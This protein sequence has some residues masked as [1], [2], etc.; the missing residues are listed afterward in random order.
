[1]VNAQEWL[2]QNYPRVLRET[3]ST[4]IIGRN[5]E[6]LEGE[7]KL[8]GFTNLK[9]F[10]CDGSN[11]LTNLDLSQCYNLE[12]VWCVGSNLTSVEFLNHFPHPEKVD[13]IFLINNN[14]SATDIDFFSRFVNL[15]CLCIGTTDINKIEQG[16][17]NRFYG[18]LYSLRNLNKLKE[19]SICSTD[20]DDGAE[21]LPDSL[22]T[23]FCDNYRVGARVEAINF[24]LNEYDGDFGRDVPELKRAHQRIARKLEDNQTAFVHALQCQA[25]QHRQKVRE[26]EEQ[27]TRLQVQ[28]DSQK[29]QEKDVQTQEKATQTNESL[30]C[31]SIIQIAPK[32]SSF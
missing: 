16:I 10:E 17:Y 18:S 32:G 3:I 23:F 20:I 8:E 26:L 7:L 27:I 11:N 21:Y 14:F 28:L 6:N 25:H 12:N 30:E 1:M 2:D 29:T 9:E 15:E 5:N 13:T 4:I 24:G 19:L 22:E 31:S